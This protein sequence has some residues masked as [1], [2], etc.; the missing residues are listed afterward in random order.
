MK[1]VYRND[2][3]V[4]AG[5]IGHWIQDAVSRVEARRLVG[6][7][8]WKLCVQMDAGRSYGWVLRSILTVGNTCMKEY[9]AVFG[10]PCALTLTSRPSS[11]SRLRVLMAP[12][13]MFRLAAFPGRTIFRKLRELNLRG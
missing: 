10:A 7:V 8:K 6:Q 4:E 9:R 11:S 3:Y 12:V 1:A 2:V 13:A 5:E